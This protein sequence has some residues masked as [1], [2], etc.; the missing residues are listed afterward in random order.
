MKQSSS[1]I[2]TTKPFAKDL[3]A[4][5]RSG[6]L[7][8]GHSKT[9]ATK[10]MK[11]PNGFALQSRPVLCLSPVQEFN[12]TQPTHNDELEPYNALPP[13]PSSSGAAHR[14]LRSSPPVLVGGRHG[15]AEQGA[16]GPPLRASAG[17][18][19]HR[20]VPPSLHRPFSVS[21]V[22][23]LPSP[24]SAISRLPLRHCFGSMSPAESLLAR[25]E[26]PKQDK[27]GKRKPGP[28]TDP[29]PKSQ[30]SVVDTSYSAHAAQSIFPLYNCRCVLYEHR[31]QLLSKN[32]SL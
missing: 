22:L 9:W 8:V 2:Q 6:L 3:S 30:G 18:L 10:N 13:P 29:L 11:W 15:G 27:E 17:R 1:S 7:P 20:C 14:G 25:R 21:L 24:A 32:I 4:S 19:V 5:G 31:S 12:N 28:P 26:Q 16:P 23:G